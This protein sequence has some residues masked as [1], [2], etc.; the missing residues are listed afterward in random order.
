MHVGDLKQQR[1]HLLA[2]LH[3]P[4][5]AACLIALVVSP[6]ALASAD[7]LGLRGLR[8]QQEGG[9][10][11]GIER[12][13]HVAEH[14]AAVR[15]HDLGGVALERMAEGVVGGDEEPAILAALTIAFPA[16]LASA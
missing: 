15:L 7:H 12:M 4:N 10:V 9:E 5:S 8:L 13:A 3:R 6:P 1:H 16:P 2:A 11:R 14:L